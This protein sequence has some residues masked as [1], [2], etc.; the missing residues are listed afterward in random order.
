MNRRE[1]V[2]RAVHFEKPEKVPFLGLTVECDFY[3]IEFNEPITWQPTNNPPHVN[4]G[5]QNF[6]N[7]SFRRDVYD[8]NS[9][10][11]EQLGYGVNWWEE[12]HESID[13]FG[14]I[15]RSSGTEGDDK[16]MGHPYSGPLQ[17]KG[18]GEGWERFEDL[19]IP[20][21]SDP[22][23]YKVIQSGRWKEIA[24]D[25]YLLG[26]LGSGGIFN[27]CSTIRGFSN[28]LIDIS[29]N[30]HPNK[31]D[32]LIKMITDY[33]LGLIENIKEYCPSLDSIM[34]ADDLGTQN[35]SFISPKIYQKHFKKYYH[36]L[37]NLTHDLG[38]DFFMHSCGDVLDLLPEF[39]DIGI[40][41]MQFDSP[42]MTG[43]E[44]FKHYTKE[45]KIAFGLSSNIQSTF[46]KGT[47]EDIKNEIQ[48][49]IKEVGNNEGGL[50]IW[51]YTS[52]KTIEAPKR[53]VRAQRKAVKKWG[54]Y[55]ESGLIDWLA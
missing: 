41:L 39:V 44:N 42:H 38:M 4:G 15:W 55:N 11:R 6:T 54:N 5:V 25:R 12:P 40:D 49:Y 19:K 30:R 8:W 16:T 48:F 35:S 47:P 46:V 28:F 9:E 29:R 37:V 53:N 51:E 52:F 34:I 2:K 50:V 27:R 22:L 24:E 3:P 32:S 31:L 45:K 43:V 7:A 20:D 17:D 1:N 26:N 14:V 36:Q 33:N 18:N 13:E 23:R 21:S 10:I